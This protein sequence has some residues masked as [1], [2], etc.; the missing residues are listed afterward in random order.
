MGSQNSLLI[1]PEMW[2]QW[3]QPRWREIIAAVRK[4]S[5]DVLLFY[6]SCGCIEPIVPGLIEAGFDVLN[7]VQPESM[8]P[9][10][11]KRRFGDRIAL[12]G[13]IGMQSTMLTGSAEEV[14]GQARRLIEAWA[15]GGGAIVTAAQ[16]MLAD[17]PWE[18][19]C[20]LV[21]TVREHSRE[22]YRRLGG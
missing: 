2:A 5:P 14:R 9:L 21:E 12:W 1:S 6:H 16:T 11:I 4:V 3:I 19:V 15:P 17:V 7:P 10:A 8:D 18:N 22:V 20:A 13:G